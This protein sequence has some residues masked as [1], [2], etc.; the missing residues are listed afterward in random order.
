MPAP[1]R[2]PRRRPEE[3]VPRV[4]LP[5]ERDHRCSA[6]RSPLRRQGVLRALGLHEDPDRPATTPL[7]AH[8]RELSR[9]I[10]NEHARTIAVSRTR[11]TS[12]RGHLR[13]TRSNEAGPR[14]HLAWRGRPRGTAV[15]SPG[16]FRRP[17]PAD[18]CRGGRQDPARSAQVSGCR[19]ARRS[20]ARARRPSASPSRSSRL[21]ASASACRPT[22]AAAASFSTARTIRTSRV[23]I[24]SGLA[25]S[26][27]STSAVLRKRTASHAAAGRSNGASTDRKRILVTLRIVSVWCPAIT[28]TPAGGRWRAP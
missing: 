6:I 28:A 27:P 24:D 15:R 12:P 25:G 17:W 9:P 4:A 1:F 10:V 19:R 21:S 14:R 26:N 11:C 18:R 20:C 13:S 8:Q 3:R 23:S 5:K 22:P 2:L 7:Q 16:R